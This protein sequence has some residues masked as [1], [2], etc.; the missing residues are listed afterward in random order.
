MSMLWRAGLQNTVV[1]KIHGR[2]DDDEV[3]E[4]LKLA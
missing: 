2:H 3:V 1:E 4:A